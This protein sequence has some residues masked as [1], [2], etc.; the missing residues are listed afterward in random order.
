[1]LPRPDGGAPPRG[2]RPPYLGDPRLHR[3]LGLSAR[4]RSPESPGT[5]VRRSPVPPPA[6]PPRTG[7]RS[8]PRITGGWDAPDAWGGPGGWVPR[9]ASGAPDAR[10]V[11]GSPP[12]SGARA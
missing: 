12:G 7:H 3:R 8:G 5:V 6:R 10:D 9:P 11:W 4:R 2:V 1:H